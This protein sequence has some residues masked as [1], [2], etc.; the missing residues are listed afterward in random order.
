MSTD[1]DGPARPRNLGR[2]IWRWLRPYAWIAALG[3]LLTL[4]V[5]VFDAAVAAFLR[6][7]IDQVVLGKSAA[8][9]RI[10][11][12]LIIAF[13]AVQGTFLFLSSYVNCWVGNRMAFDLRRQLYAKLLT[14]DSDFFDGTDS[15]KILLR[16]STDATTATAGM[17]NNLRFF[18]TRLFST[19]A[20]TVV[21]FY[22]SWW[23]ALIAISVVAIAF[24]PLRIVRQKM[25][26]LNGKNEFAGAAAS[27]IYNETFAG[28]RTIL[29]YNLAA[30]QLEKFNRLM[31]EMF[32]TSMRIVRHSNWL[33]PAMHFIVSIGLA[34][35]LGLGGWLVIGGRMTGGSFT[36]FIAALLMM[37]TPMRSIGN[38][39]SSIQNALLA[40][41][42]IREILQLQPKVLDLPP[43]DAVMPIGCGTLGSDASIMG[44]DAV[45]RRDDGR[46]ES[47]LRS[48]LPIVFEGVS[49]GYRPGQ[50]VLQDLNFDIGAGEVVGIVGHSGG[51]KTSLMQL[52]LRLYD[53]QSGAIKIGG[54][55]IRSLPLATLRGSIAAV[56]QDNFLFSATLRDNILMGRFDASESEFWTAIRGAYLEDF[57]KTLPQGVD[58]FV[59]ERGV[60]LSGGQRQR[61]AIA[62]AML[63]NAPI[64]ILD[65]A[66]SALDNRSEAVIQRALT[67]LMADRTVLII[68][69]RLS[70][71]RN[72]DRIFVLDHGRIIESGTKEDLLARP[73][74]MFKNF[75]EMQFRRR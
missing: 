55:D 7:Y 3:L 2:F 61:I 66:T 6:P 14:L 5:G 29:A 64:V 11:P 22:N 50:P 43:A 39:I 35:V 69:H 70:I 75:Y 9:S 38:N 44:H 41:E 49:F 8:Y 32:I 1:R 59:G 58:T 31:D 23:L 24:Y 57:V 21:L 68:A 26:V 47:Q 19:L 62:R 16:F 36:S 67:N 48:G 73:D 60:L 42:R 52:L 45:V 13:T 56:F 34:A 53:P 28:N 71:L 18:L 27:M 4:P 15:G 65:E 63:R 37:Y 25:R 51:G 46:S 20:L 72:V 30:S 40:L 17:I 10:I 12:L 54:H 74:G 33:S